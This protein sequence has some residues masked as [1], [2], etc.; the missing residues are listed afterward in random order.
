MESEHSAHVLV[1]ARRAAADPELLEAVRERAAQ[2][3]ATFHL[4]VPNP[5]RAEWHLLHP[6]RHDKVIKAKA[7]L[8]SVLPAIEAA[9]GAP[10]SG[11]VSIR[12][13]P[14]DVIEDALWSGHF[15]EV[16][17]VTTPHPRAHRLHLD[18][19]SRVEHLGLPVTTVVAQER[20]PVPA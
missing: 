16:M 9:A 2:S 4:V 19:V 1:V 11:S 6:M 7:V 12:H 13:D 18:L 17:I 3:P 5:A 8:A 15:N 10:V 20:S 14:M